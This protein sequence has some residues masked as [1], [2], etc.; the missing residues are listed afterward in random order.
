[1]PRPP[2]FCIAATAGVLVLAGC[3][4]PLGAARTFDDYEHKAKH[5]AEAAQ[6]AV[7]TARLTATA[8]ARGRAFGSYTSVV[9]SESESDA[10]NAHSTF[11]KI[12]PPGSRSD[13]IRTEL[14]DLLSEVDVSLS[15]L[16]ITARRGELDRL[17]RDLAVLERLSARLR[18]FVEHHS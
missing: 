3:M 12:Q 17:D 7:E 14:D 16:R 2:W 15:K 13:R 8:A 5:T 18:H 4:Q 1:M 10:A 9:L 11:D 6:S